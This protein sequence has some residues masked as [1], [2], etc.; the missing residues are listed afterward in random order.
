MHDYGSSRHF[1]DFSVVNV[2]AEIRVDH[3]LI[4]QDWADSRLVEWE[5]AADGAGRPDRSRMPAREWLCDPTEWGM[6]ESDHR[7]ISPL[8]RPPGDFTSKSCNGQI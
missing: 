1:T 3:A 6:R 2:K 7:R 4:Y 8:V 5:S